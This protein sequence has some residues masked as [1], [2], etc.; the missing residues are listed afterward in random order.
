MAQNNAAI[1][2][3]KNSLLSRITNFTLLLSISIN[4]FINLCVHICYSGSFVK[5]KVFYLI[6]ITSNFKII[7]IFMKN[8]LQVGQ[9]T[10]KQKIKSGSSNLKHP[11]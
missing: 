1:E 9:K 4:I 11:I 5:A 7:S 3:E 10:R 2:S 6:F 8:L